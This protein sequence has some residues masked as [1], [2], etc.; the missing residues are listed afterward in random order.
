[1]V[2]VAGVTTGVVSGNALI[3]MATALE[4]ADEQLLTV[5]ITV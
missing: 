2:G 3:V 4:T 1:M 5:L